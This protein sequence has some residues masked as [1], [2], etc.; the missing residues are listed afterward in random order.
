[1]NVRSPSACLVLSVRLDSYEYSLYC[2]FRKAGKC[3]VKLVILRFVEL[4][5]RPVD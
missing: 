3:D 5:Y 4:L 1:M 2:L